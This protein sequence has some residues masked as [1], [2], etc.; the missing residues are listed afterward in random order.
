M[1]TG[2]RRIVLIALDYDPTA[3]KVAEKGYSMAKA[4][5]AEVI[6]L[7]VISAPLYYSSVGNAP[8]MGLTDSM[9]VDPLLYENMDRLKTVSQNFL[10]NSKKHLGDNPFG[11]KTEI[12]VVDPRHKPRKIFFSVQEPLLPCRSLHLTRSEKVADQKRQQDIGQIVSSQI[13]LVLRHILHK[14]DNH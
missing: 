7:H 3:Q 12:L 11:P 10:D 8:I 5:N 9:G 6:L 4:M 14:A 1:K 13:Y 2:K